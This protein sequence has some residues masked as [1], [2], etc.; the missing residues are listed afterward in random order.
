MHIL[1]AAAITNFRKPKPYDYACLEASPEMGKRSVMRLSA[2]VAVLVL[3]VLVL[4]AASTA[5]GGFHYA[6]AG[7][8]TSG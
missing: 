8:V 2:A 6:Q 5:S 7:S 3:A 1:E 4:S